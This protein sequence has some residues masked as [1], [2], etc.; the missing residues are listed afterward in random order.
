MKYVLAV[1]VLREV[2]LTFQLLPRKSLSLIRL[3]RLIVF[4]VQET[5]VVGLLTGIWN[6]LV[7]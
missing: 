5:W 1:Q 7:V 4:T 2:I 3:V 6:T